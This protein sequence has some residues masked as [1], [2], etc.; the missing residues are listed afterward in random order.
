MRATALPPRFRAR[1][2]HPGLL[3]VR[4]E[5]G[6]GG[7]LSVRAAAGRGRGA[8]EERGWGGED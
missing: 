3:C 6:A 7:K 8:V 5:R 4:Q 1:P 2:R